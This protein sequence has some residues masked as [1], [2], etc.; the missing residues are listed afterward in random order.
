MM[1]SSLGCLCKQVIARQEAEAKESLRLSAR[2]DIDRRHGYAIRVRLA[3][4]K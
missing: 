2:R 3:F 4:T 1:L